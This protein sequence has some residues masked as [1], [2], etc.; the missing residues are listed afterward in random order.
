M[1]A[2][3]I[4][5]AEF[6]KSP[7]QLFENIRENYPLFFHEAT[8]SYVVSRY[9]DVERAFKD[10]AFSSRHA[11]AQFEPVYGRTMVQMD[12]R[13]HATNRN[14]VIQA[15]GSYKLNE[16]FL[17]LI[18]ENARELLSKFSS[19][20]EVELVEEF[21][22]IYPLNVIRTILGLPKEDMPFL[23]KWCIDISNFLSNLSQ[24]PQV[25]AA[26]LQS[27]KEFQAYLAPIIKRKQQNS[28]DDLLSSLCIAEIDG[29]KLT[30]DEITSLAMLL[31]GAGGETT[32]KALAL[33]F[34][35]LIVHREQ[36][37]Q[38]IADR[39]LVER[40]FTETL[41]YSPPIQWLMRLTLEDVKMTGGTIPANSMVI[42]LIAAANRDPRKYS[43][44]DNFNIFRHDLD[45]NRAFSGA[46]NHLAFGGGKHFCIG[47]KLAR[48]EVIIATNLLLNSMENMQ[49]ND[50]L[51]EEYG[52]FARGLKNL[53]I[54]FTPV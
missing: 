33:M 39:S 32:D 53:H 42:G 3:N 17:P 48:E 37:Q 10:P 54:K 5:S 1:Q 18:E 28:E 25:T 29:I 38:V 35:N 9:E 8:N 44:P 46:A 40:A 34:R 22:S 19:R 43:E 21:T 31:F 49:F 14:L 7:Y 52:F 47:T 36:L 11:E 50:K 45:V 6:D 26:G 4:L 20:G 16:K 51:P 2:P 23:K 30:D 12:G 41:R 13:E 15:L 27:R 24:N